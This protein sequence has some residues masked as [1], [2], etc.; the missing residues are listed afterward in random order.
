M[1]SAWRC[2]SPASSAPDTTRL[3]SLGRSFGETV[4]RLL[5]ISLDDVGRMSYIAAVKGLI[6]FLQSHNLFEQDCDYVAV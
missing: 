6:L 3:D 2:C 5:D 1:S 4:V